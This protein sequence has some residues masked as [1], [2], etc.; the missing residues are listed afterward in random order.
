MSNQ[1]KLSSLEV[2]CLLSLSFYFP[3]F[4]RARAA[5]SCDSEE[6]SRYATLVWSMDIASGIRDRCMLGSRPLCCS[7]LLGSGGCYEPCELKVIAVLARQAREEVLRNLADSAITA[8]QPHTLPYA[9]VSSSCTADTAALLV[10]KARLLGSMNQL[11]EGPGTAVL[12]L[13]CRLIRMQDAEGVSV[14]AC[15][16]FA[17]TSVS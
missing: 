13:R 17:H 8:V 4:Y 12:M 3:S 9:A 2:R 7:C 16:G 11:Q 15:L 6:S 10:W 5:A 1:A 14:D